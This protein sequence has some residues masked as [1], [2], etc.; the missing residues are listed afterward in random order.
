MPGGDFFFNS[1]GLLLHGNGADLSTTITDNSPNAFVPTLIGTPKNSTALPKFGTGSL[2]FNGTGDALS[3]AHNAALNL[4]TGDFTIESWNYFTSLTD[5]V[6]IVV[7]DHTYGAT[8]VSYSLVV[9][10][11]GTLRG[12]V[13]TGNSAG[14]SQDISS[15][16]GAVLIN[17]YRHLAFVR[18]GT[19]LM[20]FVDGALVATATQTGTAVDGAKALVIGKYQTGASTPAVTDQWYKGRLDELRITK[21][22]ARYTA[23]FAAPTAQFPDV[24]DLTSGSATITLSAFPVSGRG[25]GTAQLQIAP[26]ALIGYGGASAQATMPMPIVKGYGPGSAQLTI[27]MFTVEATG[28]TLEPNQ[29]HVKMPL[30]VVAGYGAATAK[31]AMPT[32]LLIAAGTTATAGGGALAMPMPT[33]AAA[34]RVTTQSAAQLTLVSPFVASG[35]GG[36]SAPLAM[37]TPLVAGAG[38]SGSMGGA[39]IT[40]PA[41]QLIATGKIGVAGNA[42]LLMPML[43]PVPSGRAVLTIPG[44]IVVAIG[45]IQVTL[46]AASFEAF[47]T[48][49]S[50]SPLGPG[51]QPVDE[52]TRYTN[53]PFTQVLR[54]NG[55]HYGVGLDGLYEI[56]GST[57]NGAAIGWAFRTGE[58]D[59]DSAQQKTVLSAYMGGRLGPDAVVTSYSGEKAAGITSH[60]YANPRTSAAQNYRQKFGR[61]A[62]ARYYGVGAADA[63]GGELVL[64]TLELEVIAMKRKI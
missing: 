15:P 58:T 35:Y 17:G 12:T 13:G 24:V 44:F 51:Q 59:F 8:F 36:A 61:G 32:P 30:P 11:D 31:L 7:K 20:L 52:V 50:H 57:D 56:G 55:K 2:L 41:F 16:P 62:K 54:F 28:Q 49:L 25:G 4:A 45:S 9:L 22:V 26:P 38:R 1:V 37:P 60:A 39:T 14:Y 5:N 23:S 21:G 6:N 18:S 34:G 43:I 29:C 10:A 63:L 53:F 33:V 3:Y 64:D 19:T 40:L 27:P 42:A 48:N 46:N 47:A